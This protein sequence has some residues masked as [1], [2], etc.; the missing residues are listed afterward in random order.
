[1][2]NGSRGNCRCTR[3]VPGAGMK[4]PAHVKTLPGSSD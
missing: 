1:M 3:S 4:A 2:K